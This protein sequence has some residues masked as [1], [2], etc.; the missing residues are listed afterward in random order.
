VGVDTVIFD[1]GGTL[2]PWKIA[3][4]RSWWRIA[5]R[6][7]ETGVIAAGAVDATAT[8]M[9][10]A[11]EELWRRARDEHISGTLAE[12]FTA[13]GLVED[14]ALYALYDEEWEWATFLDPDA[15]ALLSALRERGI[16]VGVLSNTAWPRARHQAI[17]VRDGVDHLIDGAVYTCEIPW[18]KP[19]PKAFLA[20]MAAVGAEDPARCVFVGDRVFDDIYGARAVGMRAVLVPHS[21]IP[22]VQRG[23]TDGDP[24]AVIDRLADLLAVVDA[25]RA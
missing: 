10:A 24:D 11:D 4:G 22:E 5:A 2:T 16:R 25:W 23:H 18:T 1:W 17:F 14:E 13:A 3:D 21:I 8:M 20:A 19:H 7:A 6:L 15:P 12:V 9:T